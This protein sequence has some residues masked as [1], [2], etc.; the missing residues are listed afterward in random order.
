MTIDETFEDP[1]VAKLVE[2]AIAGQAQGIQTLVKQGVNVNYVGKEGFTSLLWV[3]GSR[4][5]AGM[6]LLLLAGADLNYKALR[7]RVSA[8]NAAA[9]ADDPEFLKI[10]LEHGGGDLNSTNGD[11]DPPLHVAV[12]Q[13]RPENV[14]MLLKYGADIHQPGGIGDSTAAETAVALN[15]FSIAVYILEQGYNHDLQG[16]AE[17]AER[18]SIDPDSEQYQWKLKLLEMLK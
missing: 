6:K 1:A 16:L 17:R 2:A 18:G 4:S 12:E 11:G 3:M 13:D 8:V 10:L 5:M 9:G 15:R 14:K 7:T